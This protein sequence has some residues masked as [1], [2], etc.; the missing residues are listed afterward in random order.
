MEFVRV[1]ASDAQVNAAL[2]NLLANIPHEWRGTT[3]KNSN[4]LGRATFAANLNNLILEKG[5]AITSEDLVGIGN[6]EDYLRVSSNVS[7]VL[8]YVLAIQHGYDI[9]QVFTFASTKMAYLV[10][11]LTAG[12]PV[13][14]YLDAGE[15][16]PFSPAQLARLSELG[17]HLDIH[18]GAPVP[19]PNVVVVS[20]H[21]VTAET[22]SIVDA[23]VQPNILLINNLEHVNSAAVLTHRKRMATPITTPA[24]LRILQQL[25]GIKY[26]QEDTLRA[27]QEGIDDFYAHLQEMS[28]TDRN[29]AQYPV[30]TTAG[31]SAIAAMYLAFVDQGGVDV[32][33][34]S[35]SYGGS[36]E[37]TDILSKRTDKFHKNTFDITGNNDISAAI[38]NGLDALSADPSKLQP[39][40][41]LF[42]EIPT[43]PDMKIPDLKAVTSELL[44]YGKKTGKQVVLA[45][46]A[47]FAPGS[48]VMRKLSALAPELATLVFISL[49]K[50]VSR[51]LTTGGTIVAGPSPRSAAVLEVIRATSEMLDT[52][53]RPDQLYFLARN[54]AEVE[55]R[56]ASAYTV[57]RTV[58][59]ALCAAVKTHC[60]GHEMGLNFVTPAHAADGFTS[61]TYSFN[62]PPYPNGSQADNEALAQDFTTLL[63]AHPEFKPCVSF[64]QD[65]GLVYAT[66]PATST[67]GAIKLEDKAKQA[68][69]GVQLCRLSFPPTCDTEKLCVIVSEAVATCYAAKK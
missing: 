58:G 51:G 8:E 33:M 22:Y 57:A 40:T 61:S 69:G 32:L 41:L 67:Q 65:N 43:N 5:G 3:F 18:H 47:T 24:G 20:A 29:P 60:G 59:D 31:L 14:L 53:A 62:L 44:E 16:E 27:S 15:Q 11:M 52:N 56:C 2:P 46:D 63:E 39:T 4:L 10:L 23:V 45:V 68:V 1:K 35:T 38:Q 54:H 37:L 30:V 21:P 13:H 64:G 66:V 34:A 26:P 49:S 50:S 7:S 42:V 48:R 28:G 12:K 9:T 6:A 17:C 25:A 55:E 19:D 36:S